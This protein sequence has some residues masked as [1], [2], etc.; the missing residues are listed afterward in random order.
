MASL[1]RRVA[2]GL[3]PPK[4]VGGVG[5]TNQVSGHARTAAMA[6]LGKKGDVFFV[7]F[8]LHGREYKK[9]LKVHDRDAAE[10]ARNLVELTLHRLKAGMLAVPAGVDDGDFV[11]SGGS[12]TEPPR[13][14]AASAMPERLVP[15]FLEARRPTL[16]PGTHKLFG[17]HL[18]TWLRHL[19]GAVRQPI[20]RVTHADLDTYLGVRIGETSGTTAA[21]ERRTLQLFF[22]WA[23]RAGKLKASPAAG[24]LVIPE[25]GERHP[26]RS[27]AEVVARLERGGLSKEEVRDAWEGLYLS[28]TEIAGLL[29]VVDE[30]ATAQTS[31]LLHAIAAYT[32][33]R[34]GEVLRLRWDDID[35]AAG[36]VRARSR[37][38]SR[39]QTF[40]A[41]AVSLHPE[42][43][44]RLRA[45]QAACPRGQVV[46]QDPVTGEQ[47]EPNRANRLFWQPMRGTPWCLDGKRNWFKVGFHTYRHSFAS[48]LACAG[49]DQRVIDEFMGHGTEE[50]RKR[51]RHLYPS[52]KRAAIATFSFARV[53]DPQREA[54][55]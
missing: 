23:V 48:N 26:F 40:T 29:A 34:R 41:R 45:W 7:R 8:R 3:N 44:E 17:Y 25:D 42:L 9:S 5:L 31:F 53:A 47:M 49:V 32:G 24:L 12:I 55:K 37:K 46:L 11:V 18:G 50:M 52:V 14:Q 38:Q 16:A 43:A 30:R 21:K 33:L 51:Y 13:V 35:Y 28:P 36:T 27:S 19:D 10:A 39:R 22:A 20:D 2:T 54:D 15:A 4:R 1:R 6:N